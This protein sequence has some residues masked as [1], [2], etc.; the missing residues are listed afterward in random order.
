MEEVIFT[1]NG[2]ECRISIEDVAPDMS[3]NM[4]LRTR[5]CLM[6]AK[7][8]CQEGGCGCCIVSIEGKHPVS[9][10]S[11]N[12]AINSCNFLVLSCHG[13]DVIT[14]EGLG[15]KKKGY[16]EMQKRLAE[17][18]GS[19]CG[20]C[21]PGFVMN[22]FSLYMGKHGNVT[23]AEVEDSFGGNICRCTGYRPILDA[24]K[25]FAAD[26]PTGLRK[27][28]ED[29]EDLSISQC[30]KNGKVCSRSCDKPIHL[31]AAKGARWI[32]VYT[33]ENLITVLDTAT[34]GQYR[35]VAG[36]TA[37]GI[38][39]MPHDIE[40]FIDVSSVTELRSY[41]IEDTII[42]GG[43]VTITEW[44]SILQQAANGRSGYMYCFRVRDHINRIATVPVRNVGTLAGNLMIKHDHNEFYSDPFLLL[45]TI[46]ATITIV[47]TNRREITVTPE[48]FLRISMDKK[49]ITKITMPQ[50]NPDNTKLLTFKTT[51]RAQNAQTYMNSGFLFNITPSTGII[52][53][54]RIVYG[55]ISPG[56]VHAT[57]FE[58]TLK[59]R[60][61]FD[62]N[63]I[64]SCI[65]VI[66]SNFPSEMD[67]TID[68]FSANFRLNLALG[69]FYKA[70][71]NVVPT[72]RITPRYQTGRGPIP[73]PISSGMQTYQTTPANYPLTQPVVKN[74]ALIQCSG[75]AE[76]VNDIILHDGLWAMLVLSKNPMK[77]IVSIDASEALKVSGVKAFFSAKD[78]PGK[79]S[80]TSAKGPPLIANVVDEEVFCSGKVLYNGQPVGMIVAEEMDQA[81]YATELVKVNYTDAVVVDKGSTYNDKFLPTLQDVLAQDPNE[82][83]DRLRI[84]KTIR[85]TG[86][87]DQES[88]DLSASN[89]IHA[90]M[91][92]GPQY[93]YH[94][95]THTAL[96]IPVEDGI[97]L[98]P[99][100]QWMDLV[101]RVVAQVLGWKENSINIR[102]RR[103]GGSFGAKSTRS[104]L[105]S[106]ATAVACYHL[107]RPVKMVL[108]M[109]T[110]MRAIGKRRPAFIEYNVRFSDI[111]LIEELNTTY[112]QDVGVTANDYIELENRLFAGNAYS[113]STWNTSISAAL[114]DAPTNTW[115]RAPGATEI[116]GY[117]ETVMEHIAWTLQADPVQVRL[118]NIA[119]NG[120]IRKIYQDFI[121]QCDYYKRLEDVCQFNRRNRWKK[122]GIATTLMEFTQISLG[123]YEA[124]VAIYHAD[125][126]VALSFG[127]IE[128][129]QGLHT[130]MSQVAAYSLGVPL[131][132]VRV[133]P[134][135][136]VVAANSFFTAGSYNSDSIG[137]AIV[138]CCKVLKERL[139]P[140]RLSNPTAS[141]EDIVQEAYLTDIEMVATHQFSTAD[142]PTYA[143]YG[144][145]CAEIEVDVLT[146][147]F[148]L[149]RVDILEDTGQSLSPR[150]DVGQVEGAF[151]MGMGHWLTEKLKYNVHNGEILTT[152]A[153]N[154]K[155]PGVKDIPVDFRVTLLQTATTSGVLSS[156]ITGEPAVTM[157]VVVVTALRQAINAARRDAGAPDIFL[158]LNPPTTVEE[159]LQLMGTK[160]EQYIL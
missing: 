128:V 62:N 11:F 49:V 158:I 135:N 87:R 145:A 148:Q 40:T 111:G 114:T 143:I 2:E 116:I 99:S 17:Y 160:K 52:S 104:G 105:V 100:T 97:D 1:V 79:N 46:G 56:F 107:R 112:I 132:K 108:S 8:M 50:L 61:C 117:V 48:N 78:I 83:K 74:E 85:G 141:W 94:M 4:Y 93:H 60:I 31:G 75:E 10:D 21:S 30:P 55:G 121:I 77:T 36:N 82:V 150:I 20:F 152:R 39:R 45:E 86:S 12:L 5:L 13:L 110:N 137:V 57:T 88:K 140:L 149:H 113:S 47:D 84:Y 98:Y 90:V 26:A 58:K 154:Y 96:A 43:N 127:G 69:M 53:S 126:S 151:I 147:E 123:P 159:I 7:F 92:C 129:G 131:S 44:M 28:C 9:G 156:K 33:L 95:E 25:S 29:I 19:Q 18:D 124:L 102:V 120:P 134:P 130:K 155:P 27:I 22:M 138:E 109:D 41:S 6:G 142:L 70:I 35:L 16:H 3:L 63:T 76:F 15:D 89:E 101:Q 68:G 103:I 32:K 37:T 67:N 66:K 146:G 34:S 118:A 153:W 144:T 157:A 80:Y 81:I 139:E 14:I 71:L 42:L 59:D 64:Q 54:C 23:S 125:G 122:R 119:P 73:R 65:E 51:D 38:Y 24:W 106:C 91:N 136:N 72:N 115:M 133:K